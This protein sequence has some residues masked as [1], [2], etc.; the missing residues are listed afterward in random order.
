MDLEMSDMR[1]KPEEVMVSIPAGDL[2]RIVTNLEEMHTKSM[3]KE[4]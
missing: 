2:S 1:V 4:A 3:F